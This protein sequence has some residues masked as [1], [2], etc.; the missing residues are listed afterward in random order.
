MEWTLAQSRIRPWRRG[1]EESLVRHA[2]NYRVWRNLRD[3]FPHPYTLDDAREWIE[4]A[5]AESPVANFAIEVEGEAV[6]GIGL[7]FKE[8]IHRASAEIGYWLGEE[9]WGR[10]IMTEAARTIA[11]WA[12]ATFEI[13]RVFAGV[14]DWNPA[15]ARVL[16]K[17]G[18]Q[19]EGRMR[20]AVVKEGRVLDELIYAKVRD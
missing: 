15:S 8:D 20:M 5:L 2:N 14:I 1:D 12:L 6:G 19:F 9:Y 16:E 17:A 3:R 10:G 11:D 7:A 18:F 4:L 13:H